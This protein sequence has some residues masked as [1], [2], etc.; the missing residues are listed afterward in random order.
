MPRC[1]NRTLLQLRKG[2]GGN[3]HGLTHSEAE[4]EEAERQPAHASLSPD[5]KSLHKP[6][7]SEDAVGYAEPASTHSG[8]SIR[9]AV[10]GLVS[11]RAGQFAH[12]PLL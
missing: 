10:R 7:Q 9:V 1:A 2:F 4:N 6:A 3:Q 5:A 8:R 12:S 11:C